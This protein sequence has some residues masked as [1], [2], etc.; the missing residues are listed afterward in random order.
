[1]GAFRS[2]CTDHSPHKPW[3]S[4]EAERVL[5]GKP[6]T[7]KTFR[8]AAEAAL[9]DTKPLEHNGIRELSFARVITAV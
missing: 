1:M 7:E 5:I 3:R 8:V 9:K 6:A 4:P 2:G